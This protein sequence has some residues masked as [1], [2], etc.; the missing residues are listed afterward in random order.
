MPAEETND[1]DN[2]GC[3]RNQVNINLDFSVNVSDAA[4]SANQDNENEEETQEN[5]GVKVEETIALNADTDVGGGQTWADIGANVMA[6]VEAYKAS[7]AY[8]NLSSKNQA[9]VDA[10]ILASSADGSIPEGE[11]SSAAISYYL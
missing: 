3:G 1:C 7:E 2:D 9:I 11:S 8:T 4:T 6:D 5:K 10:L